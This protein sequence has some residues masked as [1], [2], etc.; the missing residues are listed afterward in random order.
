[1]PS[2]ST[3]SCRRARAAGSRVAFSSLFAYLALCVTPMQGGASTGGGQPEPSLGVADRGIWPD[4]DP[5]VQIA[6]PAGLTPDRV[7]ATVDAPRQ[8]LLIW[9]DGVPA[10][11]YP[12]G[13]AATLEVGDRRL[14]LRPADRAELAPLLRAGA[15]RAARAPGDRDRDGVPDALDIQIGARKTVLNAAAYTGGYRQLRYPM[16]D[17]PRAIGVCTDVVVRALRNAG[18][19]LQ[20]EVHRDIARAPRAYPMVKAGG[21]ANIDHRRVKTIL[22]WF[23]RHWAARTARVDDAGDPLRPGDVVFFDTF[24][25]R[26]GPDHIGIVSDR[27]GPS[28][29]PLVINNWTDGHVTSEMDLLSWVPVTHRFRVPEP[30]R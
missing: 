22:P 28:G 3:P 30:V 1:M 12:L 4:L 27:L 11:P 6:L 7:R 26:A 16:G 13:G 18:I 25:T 10:K 21:D 29:L 14:A 19:D 24:A 23:R 20:A 5:A 2:G 8:L 9:I 17:V 15:I